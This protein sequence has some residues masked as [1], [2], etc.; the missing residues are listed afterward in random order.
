VT[1]ELLRFFVH[2]RQQATD[3]DLDLSCLLLDREFTDA[4]HVSWT[5][6]RGGGF[7]HSG[8]LTEAPDGATEFVDVKLSGIRRDVVVP[9]VHVYSGERFDQVAEGFFG[10]MTRDVAQ[11]GLPFEP[12][13]VRLKSDLAGQGRVAIPAAF[14]RSGDGWEA[15]W[16]HLNLRGRSRFNTV[17]GHRVT[18]TTLVRDIASRRYLTVRHLVDL[19]R[20]DGVK[21]HHEVPQGAGPVTYLGF[22]AP[23]ELPEGSRVVTPRNLLDLVPA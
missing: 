21:V 13:T 19:L 9:E 3:T 8:D 23:E 17:E 18:T 14:L 16:L 2:W 10:F 5:R 20:A 12:A 6:L 1:G 15:L 22:S 7:V 4:E 11:A